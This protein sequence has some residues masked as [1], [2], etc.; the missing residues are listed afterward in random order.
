MRITGVT[1][2]DLRAPTSR[3]LAGSDAA[4]ADPDYSAAYAVLHTDDANGMQRLNQDA[5]KGISEGRVAG[6]NISEADALK[7]FTINAAWAL[8]LDDRTGSLVAGKN[9]D[10]VLWDK[11]PFSIYARAEK[12]WV[13]GA[14]LFDR[15]DPAQQW[16][17]DFEL[18]YVPTRVWP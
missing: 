5:A 4:H 17:T 10:V 2:H 6:I 8:G 15:L 14:M 11:N 9:A 1:T 16:R 12:V 13:D 3:T 7:W 18:G